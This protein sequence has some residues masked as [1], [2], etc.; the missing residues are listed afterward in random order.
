MKTHNQFKVALLVAVFLFNLKMS[1]GQDLAGIATYQTSRKM[2]IQL[3]TARIPS[4][5]REQMLEMMRKQFEKTYILSFN[6]QESSYEEKPKLASESPGNGD[7][8]IVMI[9]D[10]SGDILYKNLSSGQYKRQTDMMGKLFLVEDSLD[11]FAWVKHKESKQIGNY[12]CFK[13]TRS[14]KQERKMIRTENGKDVVTTDSI[15]VETVAWYSPQVQVAHGPS[16]YYG[17]PGLIMEVHQNGATM[18]CTELVLQRDGKVEVVQPKEGK[19]VNEDEFM[20]IMDKKM[21]AARKQ[22]GRPK[23]GERGGEEIEIRIGG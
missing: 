10:G 12:T 22:R 6:G 15:L 8:E 18:L 4:S 16:M 13:A 1:S 7:M 23:K 3:D 20:A 14:F 2:D 19:N 21:K 5:Q 11:D 17:L 9:G